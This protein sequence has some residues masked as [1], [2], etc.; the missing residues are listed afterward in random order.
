M[1]ELIDMCSSDDQVTWL[2]YRLVQLYPQ[3][4]PGIAELRA[5]F[6]KRFKPA[7]GIQVNSA[8][9]DEFPSE[10]QLG[11]IPGLQLEA[12]PTER[13]AIETASIPATRQLEAGEVS[14]D[15]DLDAEFHR[16]A[17][18]HQMPVIHKHS[19]QEIQQELYR[20]RITQA[21]VE[22]EL[23]SRGK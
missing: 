13:D 7:D 2:S 20:R 17:M 21:D 15:P 14:V 1:L 3:Q 10:A 23:A 5:C 16:I 9:Y 19:I 6:C 11:P 4:W 18:A 12:S 22:R 8:V